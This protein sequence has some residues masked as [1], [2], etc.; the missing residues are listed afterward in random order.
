MEETINALPAE[1]ALTLDNADAVE[2][3]RAAYDALTDDQK[4]LVSEE[5]IAKLEA[6]EAQ[7][8]KLQE[9]ANKPEAP[10]ELPFTDVKKSDWYYSAVAYAYTNDLMNGTSATTFSPNVTMTRAMVVT[11]LYRLAGS[12]SVDGTCR[13]TDCQSGSYYY[14]AVIWATQNGI[15]TGTSP[16]TF[17]PDKEV[18]REQMA[19]FLYRYAKLEGCDMNV[20]ETASL[21]AYPDAASVGNFAANAML[22]AVDNGIING[23]TSNGKVLLAPQ[24]SATRAQVAAILMRFCENVV[25]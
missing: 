22:W 14:N 25:K 13:F 7:I 4:A 12:P 19:T 23:T 18:T 10:V 17:V 16:T 5:A 8:A 11:V 21:S 15:T 3:A 2:S 20:S 6:A 9:E 1:D 24:E